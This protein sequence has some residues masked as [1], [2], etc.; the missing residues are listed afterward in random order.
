MNNIFTKIGD[1][2]TTDLFDRIRIGRIIF[3]N[4]DKATVTIEWL[5]KS[6]GRNEVPL[7]MPFC[8][9]GWGIY[10]MP[11]K[12]T[13][14]VC[15][16]RPYEFPVVIAY[17][18]P[19]FMTPDSFWSQFKTISNM[20]N[21]KNGELILRNLIYKAKCKVC[22]KVSY[23]ADWAVTYRFDATYN[24][25]IEHCPV[26]G[27]PAVVMSGDTIQTVNKVQMGTLFYFQQ[28]GNLRIK[29]ND[30]L[31]DPADRDEPNWKGSLIDI[32]FDDSSNYTVTGINQFSQS[33]INSAEV[34]GRNKD[35]TIVGGNIVE[36]ALK[37]K[38]ETIGNS[39]D[40]TGNKTVSVTQTTIENSKNSIENV[41][42]T[43]TENSK[44]STENVQQTKTINSK[45]T[46]ET[47]QET[48]TINSKNS[49]E[50]VTETKTI[51]S[52]N[53]QET[54]AETLTLQCKNIIGTVTEDV[55]LTTRKITINS[56]GDIQITAGTG[57]KITL[58]ADNNVEITGLTVKLTGVSTVEV[59]A[60]QIQLNG[61]NFTVDA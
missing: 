17:I 20:Q 36:T 59:D 37:S 60:P 46:T 21:I 41:Q 4:E 49:I 5:D 11:N 48:Q 53:T 55:L 30:G 43:K 27:A 29:I 42:E 40:N 44:N 54:I 24:L 16:M 47:I 19:N 28:N 2:D 56:S 38:V 13:L 8:E 6:G 32:V 52:K 15:G 23:L 9:Q 22:G 58:L 45:N 51:N 25:K 12:E 31:E 61:T 14:V 34:V 3:V 1:K 7:T 10:A 26:C 57:K 50:N 39:V 33:S 35:G 18:P